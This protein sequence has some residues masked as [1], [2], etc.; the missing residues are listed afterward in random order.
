M[1]TRARLY[2][3]KGVRSPKALA[4]SISAK[5]DTGG[6]TPLRK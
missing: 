5:A 6:Y 4:E 1:F 3:L 2:T